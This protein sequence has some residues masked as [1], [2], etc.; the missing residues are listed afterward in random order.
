MRKSRRRANFRIGQLFYCSATVTVA[1]LVPPETVVQW[2]RY[3][4]DAVA[5]SVVAVPFTLVLAEFCEVNVASLCEEMTHLLMPV[6]TQP[7]SDV[8]PDC[9]LA[10]LATKIIEGADICMEHCAP[11]VTAPCVQVSAY[12]DVLV[13]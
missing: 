12:V 3:C 13:P 5:A 1:S 7:K 2:S 6:V 4:S 8:P 11:D 9:I 10:G